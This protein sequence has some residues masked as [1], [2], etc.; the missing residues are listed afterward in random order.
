MKKRPT[1]TASP[2]NRLFL[3]TILLLAFAGSIGLATVWLRHQISAVAQSH[4]QLQAR[5]VEV[6]RRT[7][8][9]NAEIAG[10]LNPEVLLSQNSTLRL[11]LAM[12]REHQIVSVAD[13]VEVR[14]A[15]KRNSD[16]FTTAFVSGTYPL[17][18]TR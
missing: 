5:I 8:E 2:V 16:R 15:A 3:A 9:T 7:A 10:A 18:T 17:P 14:L 6:Q 12:P 1:K 11:G 4:K 13:A